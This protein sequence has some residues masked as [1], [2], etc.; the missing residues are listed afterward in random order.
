MSQSAGQYHVF[1]DRVQEVTYICPV[2]GYGMS[3][4]PEDYN[5]CPSCGTEF[6]YHDSGRTH[7][8]LRSNWIS[9]GANWWSSAVP[10]PNNW[11]PWQQMSNA[12][13]RFDMPPHRKTVTSSVVLAGFPRD[14][15]M[16]I[17]SA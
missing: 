4:P 17:K 12:G 8:Q 13:L 7:A 14:F 11:N 10:R 9:L 6:G 2:C 3:D 15:E 1:P 5:M 16:V